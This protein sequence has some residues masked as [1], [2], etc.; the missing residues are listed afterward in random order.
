MLRIVILKILEKESFIN[1]KKADQTKKDYYH[2][3]D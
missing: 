1:E 2:E 3:D